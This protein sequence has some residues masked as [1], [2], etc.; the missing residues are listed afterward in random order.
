MTTERLGAGEVV[1]VSDP[2][3]FIN[4]MLEQPDNRA[5]TASLVGSHETVFLDFS[6]T[7]ERPPLQIALRTLR[8]SASLQ[9]L[10]GVVV[11]GALALI[12]RRGRF[13]L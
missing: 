7:K 12:S 5:F 2:S 10:F 1:V 8:D 13:E 3:I 6:H 9:L 11:V 4:S